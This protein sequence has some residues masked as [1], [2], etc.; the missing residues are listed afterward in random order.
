MTI[1]KPAALLL[2]VIVAGACSRAADKPAETLPGPVYPQYLLKTNAD[3]LMDAARIAVRQ[4]YGRSALG[5]MQSGQTVHV[6][7]QYGQ[8]ENVWEAIRRAWAERGVEAHKVG[9][10][11]LMGMSEAEYAERARKNLLHGNEAAQELGVFRPVYQPFFPDDVRQQF[12]RAFTSEVVRKDMASFLDRHPEIKFF[13]AGSGG[14][15]FWERAAGPRHASKFMGNWIYDSAMELLGKANEFPGD[16][17][18]MVDDK[19]VKPIQH[20]REGSIVDP[21]GTRLRW[22]VTADQAK[23]WAGS[24]GSQNHLNIYPEMFAATVEEGV[25]KASANHTGFYPTMTVTLGRTGRVE[26]IDGG[27]EAGKWFQM[28]VENPKMKNARFPT[29]PDS[30]Y[31]YLS[32]DGF[33][34]NPKFVRDFERLIKGGPNVPNLSE[35]NRAGVQHFSFS[36]PANIDDPKDTEYAKAQGLP[37][38]HTAHMHVYFPTIKWRLA[39][40]GEWITI[41]EKGQVAAFQDPEVRALAARYGDPELLFRYEWI[42]GIPGLNTPGD[43]SR[44]YAADP[45]KWILSEWSKIQ[46]GQYERYVPDYTMKT[47]GTAPATTPE[48]R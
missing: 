45:W 25:L 27:G 3:E 1:A 20:V 37:L 2:S 36:H 41:S 33:A 24:S 15:V 9:S 5:K 16:V 26:R 46:S 17:W 8:D 38:D 28:L 7:I 14:G 40:T 32:Q 6:F 11:D 10:W 47:S 48:G 31:W 29:A 23:K 30:G 21:E 12:K 42:P 44:D 19:I 35:R 13:Y 18:N 22:T 43:Y 34:T 39:D 4:P